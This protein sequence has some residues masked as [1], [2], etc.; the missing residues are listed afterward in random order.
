MH[1]ILTFTLDLLWDK[2]AM[3][4]FVSD[5]ILTLINFLI[6]LLSGCYLNQLEME[7]ARASAVILACARALVYFLG[8]GKLLYSHTLHIYKSLRDGTFKK[9]CGVDVPQYLTQGPEFLSF[10]LMLDMAA[11]PQ[12]QLTTPQYSGGEVV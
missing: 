1:P 10:L 9:V 5:R 11:W 7:D 12:F 8:F 2:L 3:R 6:F 4:F